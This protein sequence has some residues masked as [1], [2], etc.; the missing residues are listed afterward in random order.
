MANF[1]IY[2]LPQ[3]KKK[4]TL[5]NKDGDREMGETRGITVFHPSQD[6]HIHKY[7]H[8]HTLMCSK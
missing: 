5:N 6:K 1:V 8:T 2:V 3:K 7:T 4:S